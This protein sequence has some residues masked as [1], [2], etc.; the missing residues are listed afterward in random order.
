MIL[1]IKSC[2]KELKSNVTCEKNSTL[3]YFNLLM[4]G[5]T[6]LLDIDS[7]VTTG[8]KVISWS[9]QKRLDVTAG[10]LAFMESSIVQ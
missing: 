2:T 9:E 8:G 5:Q 1:A 6:E 10:F 3:N 7:P 4:L